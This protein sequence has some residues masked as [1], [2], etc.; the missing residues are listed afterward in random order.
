MLFKIV[1]TIS[2]WIVPLFLLIVFS[3][4]QYKGI[5]IYD[6]FIEGAKEGFWLVVRLI[7]YIVCIYVAIGIFRSSSA[8]SIL[9]RGLTPVLN[10]FGI[11][12]E[13]IPLLIT[14]P[15]SGPATLGLVSELI[16]KFG[17]D[18]FIGKLASTI[19]GSTDTTLYILAVYFASVGVKNARYSLP[20]GLLA[21]VTGFVAAVYICLRIFG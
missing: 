18:S 5:K 13:V 10:L 7:P 11:P 15:L 8:L 6:T 17:P 21:D 14:R 9:T 3:H 20:V 1:T 12:G 16:D 19:D 4:A 2:V